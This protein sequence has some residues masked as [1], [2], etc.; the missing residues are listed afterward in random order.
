VEAGLKFQTNRL[1]GFITPFFTRVTD[2]QSYA[3]GQDTNQAYYYPAGVYSSTQTLGIELE[4]VY[5]LNDHLS[6]RA[7]GTFQDSKAP[8][9]R[10]W[11]LGSNGRQDDKVIETKNQALELSPN[12]MATITP[13]YKLKKFNSFVSWRYMGKRPVNSLKTFYLPAFSQFDAGLGYQFSTKIGANV[14]IN[15]LFNSTGVMAYNPPGGFANN[16]NLGGFSPEQRK[17]N[18][19]AVWSATTIQPR[20]YYLTVAYNF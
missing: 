4:G 10:A 9:S 12:V 17:A 1:T 11:D 5:E 8:V 7:V 20:S 16:L 15:N 18:P 3:L 14:N 6:V 19:N 13:A 2:I